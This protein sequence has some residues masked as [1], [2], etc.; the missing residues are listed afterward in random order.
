MLLGLGDEVAQGLERVGSF[1]HVEHVVELVDG[2]DVFVVVDAD[3]AKCVLVL[4]A[5]ALALTS[6]TFISRKW[7]DGSNTAS[8]SSIALVFLLLC[9]LMYATVNFS[10]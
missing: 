4:V 8:S 10:Q 3:G 2:D 7:T 5:L 6:S 1:C 9:L